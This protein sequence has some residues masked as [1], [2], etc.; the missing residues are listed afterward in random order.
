MTLSRRDS[1]TLAIATGLSP[2]VWAAADPA[3][4]ERIGWVTAQRAESLAPYTAAFR[5]ALAEFGRVEGRNLSIDFRY[6]NDAVERVPSL[7]DELVRQGARVIV[8]QGVAVEIANRVKPKVP[9]VYV[10]SGDPVASGFAD[11]LARPHSNM[12]GLTFMSVEFNAKR[13]E[14][15]REIMPSLK[16]VAIIANPEHPGEANEQSFTIE[17]GR[18]LGIDLTLYSTRSIAELDAA[19]SNMARDQPQAI[20]LFSDGFA[21]QYRKRII[22]AGLQLRI[23]VVAGWAV[24]AESGALFSYGPRLVD[25]YRRLAYYVDRVLNGSL[26]ADLPIEQP[27][28]FEMVLNQHTAAA[29]QVTIPPSVLVRADRVIGA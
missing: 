19:F 7:I 18:H 17:T 9:I 20:S 8:A 26:P 4:A 13:L 3:R 23:P 11:S 28:T 25:S 10:T 22:D 12:T 1:L 24:F 16:R 15:L 6:G 5:A 14:L 2:C 29:L 21:V 27:S